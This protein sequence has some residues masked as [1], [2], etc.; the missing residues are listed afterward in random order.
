MSARRW[1]FKGV[2]PT[3]KSCWIGLQVETRDVVGITWRDGDNPYE[4]TRR[5]RIFWLCILPFL[6]LVW[7]TDRELDDK[8]YMPGEDAWRE[9]IKKMEARGIKI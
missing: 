5:V 9:Y 4:V 3:W 6:P 8:R 1:R 7:V 2:Q